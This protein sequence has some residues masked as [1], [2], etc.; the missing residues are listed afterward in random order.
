MK[1]RISSKS[2][3]QFSIFFVFCLI[4]LSLYVIALNCPTQLD[5]GRV[6]AECTP[7]QLRNRLEH[8][9]RWLVHLTFFLEYVLIGRVPACVRLIN[10]LFHAGT[11]VLLVMFIELFFLHVPRRPLRRR[12][13][14][15]GGILFLCHPLA[16]MTVTYAAQRYAVM[17]L[18][19][20]LLA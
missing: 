14:L 3:R 12:F 20:M 15:M 17:G 10:L 13:A 2:S 6:W 1:L 9:S 5:D 8:G 11:A 18:F 7:E 19:F 16:T 4:G